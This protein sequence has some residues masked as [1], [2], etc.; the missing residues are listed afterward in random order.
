MGST[1][2]ACRVGC[3]TKVFILKGKIIFSF[4]PKVTG[5]TPSECNACLAL[6]HPLVNSQI[7]LNPK[8]SGSFKKFHPTTGGLKYTLKTP[9]SWFFIGGTGGGEVGFDK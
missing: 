3:K 9:P 6:N 5:L 8:I 2:G 1:T 4:Q 7:T